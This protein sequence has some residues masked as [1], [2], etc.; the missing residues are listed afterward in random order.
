MIIFHSSFLET[1]LT[2]LLTV[3]PSWVNYHCSAFNHKVEIIGVI[4][5]VPAW[6][7]PG[8]Q[9]NKCPRQV[10]LQWFLFPPNCL[11]S[12]PS[13]TPREAAQLHFPE[14]HLKPMFSAPAALDV[15]SGAETRVMME[16]PEGTKT[17]STSGLP[18]LPLPTP[19]RVCL[20][21]CVQAPDPVFLAQESSSLESRGPLFPR[22][23]AW[24]PWR[25]SG[26]PEC[27]SK[28]ASGIHL[29]PKVTLLLVIRSLFLHMNCQL[30]LTWRKV[31]TSK[32]LT[33]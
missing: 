18:S 32:Q 17:H 20:S 11:W 25:L 22:W 33:S 13:P 1:L 3:L 28:M 5:E 27:H 8:P 7:L 16:K 14:L 21:S 29:F 2:H 15:G 10:C 26:L 12:S 6:W 31:L 23:D 24:S 19:R 9:R 4:Q 30:T